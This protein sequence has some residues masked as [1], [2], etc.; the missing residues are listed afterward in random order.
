M[1]GFLLGLPALVLLAWFDGYRRA[2]WTL[3]EKISERPT[4][5]RGLARSILAATSAADWKLG[6]SDLRHE[7]SN[8]RLGII[9]AS[10]TFQL[11][12]WFDR[13]GNGIK[14][15]PWEQNIL[16]SAIRK[17]MRQ[18]RSERLLDS[19]RKHDAALCEFIDRFV[20]TYDRRAAP[21][22]P[23]GPHLRAVQ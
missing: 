9:I 18:A 11:E 17:R 23:R 8:E 22:D 1:L 20:E 15:K 19:Q 12:V 2:F 4:I 6:G 5:A 10:Y 14:F 13:G 21:I 3:R 16:R 7:V